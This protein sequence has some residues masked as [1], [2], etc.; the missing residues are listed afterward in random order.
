VIKLKSHTPNQQETGSRVKVVMAAVGVGVIATMGGLT[1]A[2][3]SDEA[4]GAVHFGGA[5]YTSTQST[6]PTQIATP[7]AKPVVTTKMWHK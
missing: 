7:V 4:Q 1:I 3:G 5:G 2:F 6:A